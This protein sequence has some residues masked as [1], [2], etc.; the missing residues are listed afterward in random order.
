M[1]ISL[2][3]VSKID[4]G[5]WRATIKPSE[6]AMFK[7]PAQKL[8]GYTILFLSKQPDFDATSKRLNFTLDSVNL[9]NVGTYEEAIITSYPESK[10]EGGKFVK[11]LIPG[12]EN[13]ISNLTTDLKNLGQK[14][15]AGVRK[16]HSGGLIFHPQSRKYVETPN[17]WT[18]IIQPRDKSLRISVYGNPHS[19]KHNDT[20]IDL[21]EDMKSYSAFKISNLEQV[22]EAISIIMTA[23][24]KKRDKRPD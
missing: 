10:H 6:T 19:F 17:F 12:D 24:E 3:G 4:S 8:G 7:G 9:L 20:Y 13:F 18:V 2:T 5:I 22:E 21:K 16:Q 15:L 14:L 11:R 1:A 23:K